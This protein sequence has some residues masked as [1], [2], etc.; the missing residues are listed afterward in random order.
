MRSR[1]VRH[2]QKTG[3]IPRKCP[4]CKSQRIEITERKRAE[5][6]KVIFKKGWYCQNCGYENVRRYI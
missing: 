6:N 3:K 2:K 4:N 1:E 5:G